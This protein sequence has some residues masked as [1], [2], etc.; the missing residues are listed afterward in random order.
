M[1]TL[2]IAILLVLSIASAANAQ[3]HGEVLSLGFENNYRP[4]CW[5]PVLVNIT[6]ESSKTDFFW[7]Q[8]KQEDLDRD[9]PIFNRTISLTGAAEGQSRPQK[10]RTY[11]K[12]QPTDGGLAESSD[13]SLTR[14]D[15]QSQLD[16]SLWTSAGKPVVGLPI[17]M[18][19][20][21]LDP[22]NQVLNDRRGTRFVLIVSDGGDAPVFREYR[23][24]LGLLEVVTMQPVRTEQLPENVLGYDA[25]DAIVW[26]NADPADLKGGGDDKFRALESWVRRGG[27]LIICTTSQWQRL[28]AF[29]DM[30]PVVIAGTGFT[31]TPE[32]LRSLLPRSAVAPV[33]A[34]AKDKSEAPQ[35]PWLTMH[36]PFTMAQATP[37]P[38]AIVQ[39]WITW[40]TNP[41]VRTPWLV[42]KPF[43]AGAVTWVAQ[44]LGDPAIT[45]QAS[46]GW[47]FIW[48]R[49]L[50]LRN[51]PLIITSKTT[52]ADRA[53]YAPAPAID[54]GPALLQKA[55]DLGAKSLLL[56][57]LAVAFFIGYWL[58]AG[59]GIYAYLV[60]RRRTNLSWFMFATAAL[61]ATLLTVVLVRVTLRG[62]PELAHLTLVRGAPGQPASA[63]SRFGLYIPR[64]GVQTIELK[65]MAP[66]T[67]AALTAFAI[68]P[69][70]LT[71]APSNPGPEYVVNIHDASS[72]EPALIR[73]PFRSTL[74]K[75]EA[76]W[77]G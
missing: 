51:D 71:K 31:Q 30:L 5:T 25:V 75:F 20:S 29:G 4:D 74:K 18:T 70:H 36:G 76:E 14:D 43:G 61:A 73:V 45:K 68:H 52:D 35:N 12:P 47:P 7:L 34:S 37:R 66:N 46:S 49:V 16:V 22:R 55:M 26:M 59:P 65:D 54:V 24:S 15:L 42:R 11:F 53:P 41:P 3:A 32:P 56:T 21:S 44:N 9:H 67:V 72:A 23:D 69:Q 13:P 60:T 40:D 62:K 28:L 48:D 38:G 50:G 39:D 33:E 27:H 1:R 8:I 77:S 2:S 17:T 63:F 19:I 57:A 6:P 10:F 58:V 64:D